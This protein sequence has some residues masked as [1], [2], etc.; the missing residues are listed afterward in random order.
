MLYQAKHIFHFLPLK[1]ASPIEGEYVNFW[2][3]TYTENIDHQNFHVAFLAFHM[4]Y[5]TAVYFML[6]KIQSN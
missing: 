2:W 1:Y 4:L 3:E 5:M 6:Y